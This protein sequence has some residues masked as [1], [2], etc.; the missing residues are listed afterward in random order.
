MTHSE[1]GFGVT[2]LVDGW[3]QGGSYLV[4]ASDNLETLEAVLFPARKGFEESRVVASEVD[5]RAFDARVD[6]SLEE[7]VGGREDL[8]GLGLGAG[9]GRHDAVDFRGFRECSEG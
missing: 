9:V 8:N 5:E 2:F 7:D 4:R 6:E 3:R 1:S